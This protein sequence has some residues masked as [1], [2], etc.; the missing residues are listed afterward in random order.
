ME[1]YDLNRFM[2]CQ[3]RLLAQSSREDELDTHEQAAV[4]TESRVMLVYFA[5]AAE[6]RINLSGVFEGDVYAGW[7]DPKTGEV[8]GAEKVSA[9]DDGVLS[10]CSKADEDAILILAAD[11]AKISVPVG[12]YDEEDGPSELKKV[13]EW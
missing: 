9:G 6:E 3:E 11:P 8:S 5:C 1:A 2:P 10:I 13:F 4:D 12:T 7:F